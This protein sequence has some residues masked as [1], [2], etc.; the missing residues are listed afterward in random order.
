MVHRD[1]REGMGGVTLAA[2]HQLT[3]LCLAEITW[4][5]ESLDILA[6]CLVKEYDYQNAAVAVTK[7]LLN[8]KSSLSV[9]KGTLQPHCAPSAPRGVSGALAVTPGS[10][11]HPGHGSTGAGVRLQPHRQRRAAS[12]P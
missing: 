7:E 11:R 6:L 5:S 4:Y 2:P 1:V 9:G 12:D 10:H 3:P 8:P